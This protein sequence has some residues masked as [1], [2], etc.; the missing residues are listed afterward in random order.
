MCLRH[1]ALTELEKANK[2]EV[3]SP[4]AEVRG[5]ATF[6]HHVGVK[7]TQNPSMYEVVGSGRGLVVVESS[8]AHDVPARALGVYN[9]RLPSYIIRCV[10]DVE[11]SMFEDTLRVKIYL[12]SV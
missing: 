10:V 9:V 6:V 4:T 2:K 11:E 8:Q 7:Y 1:R 3:K 5:T 12:L